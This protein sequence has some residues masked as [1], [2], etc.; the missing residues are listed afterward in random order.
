M[1]SP[2]SLL[3]LSTALVLPGVHAAHAQSQSEACQGLAEILEQEVP[4]SVRVMEA[5]LRKAIEADENDVCVVRLLEVSE[6]V[7]AER[8]AGD[9]DAVET[10]EAV[11][12]DSEEAVLADTETTTL[13]LRDEVAVEGR[14]YLETS[15]PAVDVTA[16]DTQVDI[17]PGKP[18]VTVSEGQGSILIR[19]APA[20]V[21]VDMPTPTIRIVQAAPEIV[22]TMPDPNVDVANAKPRVDVRQSDPVV[23]VTQAPPAVQLELKRAEEGAEP[24]GI[25][26]ND[27]RTGTDYA[28]GETVEAIKTEDATVNVTGSEPVVTMVEQTDTAADVRIERTQPSIRFE[29]AEPKVSFGST[30][31][32]TIEFVRSGEPTVTFRKDGETEETMNTPDAESPDALSADGSSETAMADTDADADA[33]AAPVDTGNDAE[34]MAETAAPD[35]PVAPV[36]EREGFT[37]VAVNDITFDD[38]EGATLY[39]DNDENIGEIGDLILSDDGQIEA[40]IVEI[41]GFLGIGE[42]HVALPFDRVNILRS[43]ADGSLRVHVSATREELEAMESY[44]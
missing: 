11:A 36:F 1:K 24:A 16:G 23:T 18:S 25:R 33:V 32:P 8:R 12:V 6:L 20:E 28:A 35:A 2:L 17:E 4:E 5:D 13:T 19:Q 7:T 10:D 15:P 42:K 21:T 38:L 43:D 44:R 40:A 27:R 26:V 9:A 22:I 30:G 39:G 29:Q 41:G 31:E 14:V 34:V 37:N 3:M